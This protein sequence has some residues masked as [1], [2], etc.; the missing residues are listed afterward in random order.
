MRSIDQLL[1]SHPPQSCA[2]HPGTRLQNTLIACHD[3]AWYEVISER[4]HMCFDRR[5]VVQSNETLA[6]FLRCLIGLLSMSKVI[7]CVA[8]SL[9]C[10][11][12]HDG[13]IRTGG[14]WSELR[15]L[16]R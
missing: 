5:M 4:S 16:R 1:L 10:K 15:P 6:F 2:Y 14:L 11:H 3:L 7:P 13:C 8:L 12:I 9:L